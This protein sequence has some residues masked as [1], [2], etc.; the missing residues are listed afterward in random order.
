M[1]APFTKSIL[2]LANSMKKGGR[3]VAGIEVTPGAGAEYNLGEWI[4]P[5]DPTQDE[6]TIPY[7]RTVIGNRDLKLLDCVKIR[8]EGECIPVAAT[9]KEWTGSYGIK[10]G[11]LKY[12]PGSL[13][14]A[15]VEFSFWDGNFTITHRIYT[16]VVFQENLK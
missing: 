13:Q 2:V 8:F 7:H 12:L 6:G 15:L 14:Q 3:C 11:E 5:I 4:R 10:A 16:G 1:S 9:G